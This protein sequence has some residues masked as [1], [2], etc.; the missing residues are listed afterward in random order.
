MKRLYALL[1]ASTAISALGISAAFADPSGFVSVGAGLDNLTYGFE[2]DSESFDGTAVQV[3]AS[4]VYMFTPTLGAQGDV[5]LGWREH[6]FLGATLDSSH[7]DGALHGFYREP[8]QFLV[9]SFF[10]FGGDQASIEG[11]DSELSRR[12][13]GA[14]GQIYLDNL[15]LY[16]QAGWQQME[17]DL[18]GIS[19]KADGFFGSFEARY[20]LTPDLRIDGHVGV[21][22]W[23]QSFPVD[24][25]L[26]TVNLG[27]GA[28]YKLENLPISLFASYDHYTTDYDMDFGPTVD[29]DRFLVGAKI[30]IGEDS[31]LDRD[32]NGASLKPVDPPFFGF[33]SAP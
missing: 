26:T 28:E 2:G 9:G 31:L 23:E 8:D 24:T 27:I 13:A 7:I 33:F 4:G 17:Q 21:S 6:D 14:E 11:F 25:K 30:A 5:I 19:L 22:T 16:G 1:A 10:Q 32:R 15:T 3:L 29:R 18:S 20:F 12:Y